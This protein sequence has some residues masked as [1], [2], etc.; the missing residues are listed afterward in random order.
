M[1]TVPTWEA[2]RDEWIPTLQQAAVIDLEEA[3]FWYKRTAEI[4]SSRFKW[5]F[6]RL[7]GPGGT[8]LGEIVASA[9]HEVALFATLSEV[10]REKLMKSP[11]SAPTKPMRRGIVLEPITADFFYEDF[12][13]VQ[14]IDGVNAINNA[15]YPETPWLK[16]NV[17]DVVVIGNRLIV[18]DY[19]SSAETH[20]DAPI[21]YK[22]QIHSYR[23]ILMR[24]MQEG[25]VVIP[26]FEPEDIELAIVYFDYKAGSV[27]PISVPVSEEIHESLLSQGQ[28]FWD[29]VIKGDIEAI[30]AM[31]Y[32]APR[33][34]KIVYEEDELQ[35]LSAIEDDWST[36]N[37]I[38][39]V[40]ETTAKSHIEAMV[41]ILTHDGKTAIKGQKGLP[42]K[43]GTPSISFKLDEA[44]VTEA[45]TKREIHLNT[46]MSPTSNYDA[47]KLAERLMELDEDADLDPF[48][49]Q[50]MD[51]EKVKE[52]Y[53]EIGIRVP[54]SESISI[55][56]RAGRKVSKEDLDQAKA[57]IGF[58]VSSVVK[59]MNA[60]DTE[61]DEEIMYSG[62]R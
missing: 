48:L 62:L 58:E 3:E 5:H 30:R 24:E 50:K 44:S 59:R 12:G 35:R 39:S 34:E 56:L 18:V 23:A 22:G 14:S 25:R 29:N 9:M 13:A 61:D 32:R 11:P 36:L 15:F 28:M 57:V 46:V 27:L 60:D 47:N 55:S 38:N 45:L 43:Q 1:T 10:A 54:G 49:I 33:V 31:E 17:D 41:G 19:K 4:E 40:A 6:E 37:L 52:V 51:I 16:G 7:K 21:Q 26:G 53:E 8:G 42:L 20:D 2:F